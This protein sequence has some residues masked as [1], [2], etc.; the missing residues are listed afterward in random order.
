MHSNGFMV[1][2]EQHNILI[3]CLRTDIE[4]ILNIFYRLEKQRAE[5]FA[6]LDP[7]NDEQRNFSI[8]PE[9]WNSVQVV[10]HLMTSEKLSLI[11]MKRMANSD[12]NLPTSGFLSKLRLQALKL[13]FNLPFKY[14]APRLTDATGKE[15]EY[16][17][18]KSDW[19]TVRSELR[20][21]IKTLDDKT[22]KSEILK[23]P[24]VGMINM[25]QAL[26]FMETHIAHHKKQ[27]RGIINHPSFPK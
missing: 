14:K 18:L 16:K 1:M 9:K 20:S 7:L 4:T 22:L 26:D 25:K 2:I 23:H 24:R 3:K 27:I 6:E 21:L 5:L 8:A 12:E 17:K 13:A 11:Y 19:N 15:P 10:L